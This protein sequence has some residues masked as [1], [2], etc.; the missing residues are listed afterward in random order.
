MPFT[1]GQTPWNKGKKTG[2]VPKTAFKKGQRASPETEFKKGHTT[3]NKG[4]NICTGGGAKKGVT[5]D[6]ASAWKGGTTHTAAGYIEVRTAPYEKNYQHRVVMEK[7]LE[8]KLDRFEIVHH[9]D[10]D[11]TN[12]AIE[13]LEVMSI[14]EHNRIHRITSTPLFR[15]P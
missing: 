9:I 13:N 3:W 2:I 8:R 7:H 15:Q 12:N 14:A 1:K 10:F 11:K 5:G 6:K 4:T